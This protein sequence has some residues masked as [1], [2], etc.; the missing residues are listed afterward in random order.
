MKL[1]L[2]L[3]LTFI[4]ST[5]CQQNLGQFQGR[6][7]TSPND[8]GNIRLVPLLSAGAIQICFNSQESGIF[9]SYVNSELSETAAQVSCKQLGFLNA[10]A[11]PTSLM[12]EGDHWTITTPAMCDGNENRLGECWD[13][14]T[15][16]RGM[17]PVAGLICGCMEGEIRLVA[18]STH[19]EGRIELCSNGSWGTV[20]GDGWTEREAALVCSRLGY[21]T[22]S[23]IGPV[24]NVSCQM[25]ETDTSDC[26]LII[27][28]SSCH[29]SMDVG[30]KCLPFTDACAVSVNEMSTSNRQPPTTTETPQPSDGATTESSI[31]QSTAVSTSG[32]LGALIGLLAAALVV[33]V[34]GW[35]V[36][37]AYFQRKINKDHT[38]ST[39][40]STHNHTIQHTPQ[41]E[42]LYDTINDTAT[43]LEHNDTV[44]CVQN[45]SYSLV[46]QRNM[47]TQNCVG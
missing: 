13:R 32:T 26:N 7:C 38:H 27:T 24:Y 37:C 40:V 28:P 20:C 8:S 11:K 2:V 35:I 9:W 19:R 10:R 22:L 36:S 5:H 34:T 31:T 12:V 18:G 4:L 15:T 30:V 25:P 33:V 3:V 46:G 42:T 29:H 1:L 44:K 6:S 17:E 23:G 41:D 43:N 47:D 14:I 39:P 21:P 16:R 45:E